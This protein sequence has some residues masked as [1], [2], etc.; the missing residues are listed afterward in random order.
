MKKVVILTLIISVL[1][2]PLVANAQDDNL[3]DTASAND[4]LSRVVDLIVQA[5]LV[6]TLSD[7]EFTIFAPSNDAFDAIPAPVLNGITSSPPSL[8]GVLQYHVLEGAYD[9]DALI[10]AESVVTLLGAPLSFSANDDGLAI[11][12]EIMVVETIEASNGV[13]HVIDGVLIPERPGATAE[14]SEET[15]DS[16]TLAD[17]I[18]NAENLAFL[19]TALGLATP[20]QDSLG[21]AMETPAILF[22]PNDDAFTALDDEL[23]TAAISDPNLLANIL[24]YHFAPDASELDLETLSDDPIELMTALEAPL[25]LTAS[26]DGIMINESVTVVEQ[27]ETEN[28]VIL[29]IDGVLLPP[30]DAII[31]NVLDM[32]SGDMDESMS[33]APSLDINWDPV[34]G[35]FEMDELDSADD[36]FNTVVDPFN[37]D[38]LYGVEII[39]WTAEYQYT[40]YIVANYLSADILLW[41]NEQDPTTFE[42]ISATT[43]QTMDPAEVEQLPEEVQA[44]AQE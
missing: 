8:L 16:N 18:A 42:N 10:E 38:E 15:A 5:E 6:D 39:N 7:G 1:A 23:R 33:D 43:I 24:L 13:I 17:A 12:V 34:A 44:L 26:D 9:A 27:I 14:T 4:D 22:A 2:L 30:D 25:S 40:G 36:F 37:G 21:G 32:M 20:I 29:V 31:D 41:M 28:G 19:N 35:G 3:V 11:N